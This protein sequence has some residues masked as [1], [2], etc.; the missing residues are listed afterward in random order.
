MIRR[1]TGPSGTG[2]TTFRART[3]SSPQVA[4]TIAG[5]GFDIGIPE[6]R[7]SL[8]LGPGGGALP[9]YLRGYAGS[10]AEDIITDLGVNACKA[11]LPASVCDAAA[12]LLGIG[13]PESG[14]PRVPGGD[15]LVP[16]SNG[17]GLCGPGRI[18]FPPW[19]FDPFPGGDVSGAG[20]VMTKGEPI[21]GR[22]GEGLVPQSV[23]RR[24]LKCPP[25]Y[26][27]GKDEVCYKGLKNSERKWP[28][29]RKPLLTGGEL[30]AIS[31]ADR[32]AGR[33]ETQVKKLTGLGLMKPR[34]RTKKVYVCPKCKRP[35]D[36]CACS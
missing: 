4:R 31:T 3:T 24:R 13:V 17:D 8:G 12:D 35:R 10:S 26:V 20:L 9:P 18:G 11:L 29:G 34:T 27:L 22:Y 32:A 1:R 23:S 33:V 6:N 30:N 16:D 5:P 2:T 28:K 14:D 21:K 25:G 19:C 7:F 36:E 15:S